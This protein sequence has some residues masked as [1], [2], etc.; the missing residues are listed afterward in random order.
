MR[1][2][3]AVSGGIGRRFAF[4]VK[5]AFKID[6]RAFG[7]F[8]VRHG[9]LDNPGYDSRNGCVDG[10]R[11]FV[12][13]RDC[14]PLEHAVARFYRKTRGSSALLRRNGNRGGNVCGIQTRIFIAGKIEPFF[15]F[16]HTY[17]SLF[18]PKIPS[19]NSIYIKAQRVK[20]KTE[21]SFCVPS[22]RR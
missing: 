21:I 17:I 6:Y 9:T 18:I 11:R 10:N 1:R 12:A 22:D 19:K 4:K 14:L 20:T 16:R 13:R 3:P 15:S 2:R 5:T 7:F 8:P